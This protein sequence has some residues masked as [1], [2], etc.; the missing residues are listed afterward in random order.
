[1]FDIAQVGSAYRFSIVIQILVNEKLL[2]RRII[3]R[4]ASGS[5]VEFESYAA[6]P[7]IVRDP[8]LDVDFE[9]SAD[10]IEIFYSPIINE[11][12]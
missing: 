2:K 7:V 10:K 4:C 8:A 3:I 12:I 9:T 6:I 11:A 5:G 1:M